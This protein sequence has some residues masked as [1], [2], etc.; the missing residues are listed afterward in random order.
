MNNF[1]SCR[2]ERHSF[3]FNGQVVKSADTGALDTS[4]LVSSILTLT[5]VINRLKL[6]I[7]TK[8]LKF[9]LMSTIMYMAPTGICFISNDDVSNK[10]RLILAAGYVMLQCA[11]GMICY[12]ED[13]YSREQ[14]QKHE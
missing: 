12:I 8:G 11:V 1:S 3:L 14:T 13:W 6:K 7:M 5:T 9:H 10:I 2:Y 4:L